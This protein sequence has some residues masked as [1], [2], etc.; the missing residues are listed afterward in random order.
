MKKFISMLLS[1]A[2]VLM[3][4][5]NTPVPEWQYTLNGQQINY[6]IGQEVEHNGRIYRCIKWDAEDMAIIVP[7]AANPDWWAEVE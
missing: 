1:W 6:E 2:M 4:S 3:G 5:I 7:P